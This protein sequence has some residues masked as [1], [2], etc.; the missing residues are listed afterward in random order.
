MAQSCSIKTKTNFI[1]DGTALNGLRFVGTNSLPTTPIAV[2]AESEIP[3]EL[4]YHALLL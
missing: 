3:L 1:F 4:G 2:V